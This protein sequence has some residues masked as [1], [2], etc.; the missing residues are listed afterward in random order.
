M[1]FLYP[2]R[3][4]RLEKFRR[5]SIRE[6]KKREERGEAGRERDEFVRVSCAYEIGEGG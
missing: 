3:A 1:L 5:E 4:K 2:L 6:Q